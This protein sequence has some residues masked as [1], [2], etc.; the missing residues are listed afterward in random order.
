MSENN[1]ERG[2][3]LKAHRL[4]GIEPEGPEFFPVAYLFH[5]GQVAAAEEIAA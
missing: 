5:A 4:N 2:D 3:V 1:E